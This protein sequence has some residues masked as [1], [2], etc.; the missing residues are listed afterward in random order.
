[1]KNIEDII[2]SKKF[3]E[4]TSSE[5]ELIKDLTTNEEEFIQMKQFLLSVASFSQTETIQP[6]VKGNLDAIFNSKFQLPHTET[7]YKSTVPKIIPFYNT[8]WFRA[9]AIFIIGIGVATPLIIKNSNSFNSSNA[10]AQLETNPKEESTFKSSIQKENSVSESSKS[11]KNK[12]DK[13]ASLTDVNSEDINS[14]SSENIN[15]KSTE[16]SNKF[17]TSGKSKRTHELPGLP[18]YV[19]KNKGG[20]FVYSTGGNEKGNENFIGLV[21]SSTNAQTYQFNEGLSVYD[22]KDFDIIAQPET[23]DQMLDIIQAVY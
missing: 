21:A 6:S 22:K 1:M 19:R 20:G 14:S 5:F 7:V 11:S 10:V 23:T 2:R 3:E 4:L 15:Y 17:S 8:L 13:T 9:A 12:E 18:M 16:S